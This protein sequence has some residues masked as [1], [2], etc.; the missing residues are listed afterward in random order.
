[1]TFQSLNQ[2]DLYWLL[3]SS[4]RAS[5]ASCYTHTKKTDVWNTVTRIFMLSLGE[6]W[7]SY[8]WSMACLFES[9]SGMLSL[10]LWFLLDDSRII[11]FKLKY[12]PTSIQCWSFHVREAKTKVRAHTEVGTPGK[13]NPNSPT[14]THHRLAA[15]HRLCTMHLLV[16]HHHA[17]YESLMLKGYGSEPAPSYVEER[18]R[19]VSTKSISSSL[20]EQRLVGCRLG[21]WRPPRPACPSLIFI[22]SNQPAVTWAN[23]LLSNQSNHTAQHS[24]SNRVQVGSGKL[25]IPIYTVMM[26]TCLWL[27]W[28]WRRQLTRCWPLWR[29]LTKTHGSALS[30]CMHVYLARQR[31]FLPLRKHLVREMGT[32]FLAGRL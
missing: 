1:M 25:K 20:G 14:H 19:R 17:S 26:L 3:I 4:S 16:V 12:K 18:G 29:S 32:D 5:W 22:V 9:R 21:R 8:K 7:R 30:V 24:R 13:E 11:F 31:T 6:R 15:P 2:T 28:G 27:P 23:S 10:S